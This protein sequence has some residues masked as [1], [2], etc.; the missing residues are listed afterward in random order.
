MEQWRKQQSSPAAIA[1]PGAK[2]PAATPG[3]KRNGSLH[4]PLWLA[5][6]LVIGS[7]AGVGVAATK[8]QA[9]SEAALQAAGRA[10]LRAAERAAAM[11][12]SGK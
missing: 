1:T 12:P 11:L 4:W 6:I 5:E 8:F 10:A 2:Q 9:Q 7:F 3:T